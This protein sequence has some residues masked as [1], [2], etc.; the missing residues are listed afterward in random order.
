MTACPLAALTRNHKK[1]KQFLE[2]PTTLPPPRF[3]ELFACREKVESV[4]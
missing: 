3:L 2:R 4:L 1:V